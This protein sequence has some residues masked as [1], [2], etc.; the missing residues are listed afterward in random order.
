MNNPIELV[1]FW[2]NDDADSRVRISIKQWN[3]ILQGGSFSRSTWGYYEGKRER[4]FWEI[5]NHSLNISGESGADYII[6][7]SIDDLF[8]Y[9]LRKVEDDEMP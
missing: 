5:D 6:D 7:G 8:V 4:V 2:G 3:V 1:C 9:D